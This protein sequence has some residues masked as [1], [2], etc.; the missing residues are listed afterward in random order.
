MIEAAGNRPPYMGRKRKMTTMSPRTAR[1]RSRLPIAALVVLGTLGLAQSALAQAYPSRPVRVIVPYPP[2]GGTDVIMRILAEPLTVAM[3]TPIVIDNRGGAAGAIGTDA[4]AKS[5]ADGYTLL[6]TLSSHT[7]NPGLFPKLSF[8]TQKDFASISL[9]V[10]MPQ[11]LVANNNFQA[12]TLRELIDI[13]KAKP[14]S[15]NYGS[16]GAGSPAHIAG[17]LLDLQA[18]T[19]MQHVPYRGGGPALTAVMGGETQLL[20]VSIPAAAGHA[21]TGRVR[22]LAVTTLKRSAV[23]PDVPTVAESGYPSF[24]VDSWYAM[25]APRGTAREIVD[26]WQKAIA[27]AVQQPAVREKLLQQGAE[28]VGST[29]EHLDKVVTA[30]IAKWGEIIA[31]ANIKPE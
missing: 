2:G 29:S 18:G 23:L 8:D 15:I 25:F 21:K 7:I 1:V 20:W 26:M 30:E 9:A 19:Q 31:K 10:S 24:E 28:G 6:F 4:V 17:E 12:K 13:A 3:K 16:V 27:A 11:I 14:K 5:A 22:P